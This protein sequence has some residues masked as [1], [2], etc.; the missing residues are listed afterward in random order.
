MG[1]GVALTISAWLRRIEHAAFCRLYSHFGFAD[2][3]AFGAAS[4]PRLSY[5]VVDSAWT[6]EVFITMNG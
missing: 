3:T 4:A 6:L 1:N 5:L 2:D